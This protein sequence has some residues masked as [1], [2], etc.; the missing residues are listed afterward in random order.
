M[1]VQNPQAESL[2]D[3]AEAVVA[4]TTLLGCIGKLGRLAPTVLF[5][6]SKEASYIMGQV[7][8]VDGGR[9]GNESNVLAGIV[10]L[11]SSLQAR[12]KIHIE[13]NGDQKQM[14]DDS[15]PFYP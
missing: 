11:R 15:Y 4:G 14:L 13:Q 9:K 3:R 1:D 7:V 8:A 12:A 2:L 10:T 6:T 5:L